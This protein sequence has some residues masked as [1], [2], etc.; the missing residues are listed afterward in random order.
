VSRMARPVSVSAVKIV[1]QNDTRILY[2]PAAPAVRHGRPAPAGRHPSGA[3][4][5]DRPKEESHVSHD[6]E[7]R[8]GHARGAGAVATTTTV[9]R[10][11]PHQPQ[12]HRL[13]GQLA[14]LKASAGEGA[15]IVEHRDKNGQF[16][17]VDDLKLV[18][19]VGD[20]TLEQPAA[21]D[22]Q[23]RRRR[24]RPRGSR[25]RCKVVNLNCARGSR[26]KIFTARRETRRRTR[27]PRLCA[28][29]VATPLP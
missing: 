3:A 28:S 12:H 2:I 8:S 23:R 15:A 14:S 6:H 24:R 4:R 17:S 1:G 29:A 18:R 7:D 20:K 26:A 16:K 27:S 9:P 13:G 21:G 11:D 10:G 22:R 5:A 25:C 19:G